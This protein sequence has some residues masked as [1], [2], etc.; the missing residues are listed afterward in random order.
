M[1]W[2]LPVSGIV[3]LAAVCAASSC[4]ASPNSGM[5]IGNGR[6]GTLVWT[7]PGAVEF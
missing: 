4:L 1:P 7:T 2:R 6:M 5:P 3:G